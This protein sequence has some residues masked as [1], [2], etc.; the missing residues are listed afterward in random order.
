MQLLR[1]RIQD[2]IFL[3]PKKELSKIWINISN[4]INFDCPGRIFLR[5]FSF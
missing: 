4:Y 5:L 1:N 3:F 2:I